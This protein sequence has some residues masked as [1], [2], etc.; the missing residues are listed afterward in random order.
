MA[1]FLLL[2]PSRKMKEKKEAIRTLLGG[3]GRRTKVREAIRFLDP[4]AQQCE[5]AFWVWMLGN[6][7]AHHPKFIATITMWQSFFFKTRGLSWLGMRTLFE[8]GVAVERRKLTNWMKSQ[9]Q[10]TER[11]CR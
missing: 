5:V 2:H 8:Q 4:I 10:T 9:S 11:F 6:L 3:D 1:L 7:R